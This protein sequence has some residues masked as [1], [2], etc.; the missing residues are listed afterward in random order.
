MYFPV[1]LL[2]EPES[3]LHADI[4]VQLAAL[5]NSDEWIESIQMVISS[6]SPIILAAS[7]RNSTRT[8]WAIIENFSLRLQK[9]V[10]DVTSED[11]SFAGRLMGDP[12]FDAYFTA[13]SN[14]ALI[15]LEDRRE[16][17]KTKFEQAGIPVGKALD[18]VSE[19]KKYL[20]VFEALSGLLNRKAF[21]ILDNDKGAK[22]CANYWKGKTPDR[23]KAGFHRYPVTDCIF[24]VLLPEGKNVEGLFEE[25]DD[26]LEAC[27]KDIYNDDYSFKAK[28]PTA[29]SRA[30]SSL[31]GKD[32]P[33]SIDEAKMLLVNEKDVK[34][35]FWEKVEEYN[36]CIQKDYQSALVDLLEVEA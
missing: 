35:T 36:Y 1:W 5:L 24:V 32:K 33:A 4:A 11:I 13:S 25:Y 30:T 15:F 34:D 14:Q 26:H 22:E 23:K 20:A 31:R 27:A 28:I 12:N 21:F 9:R 7:N 29:L 17:T 3:F 19:I 10:S 8:T 2:E 16:L 6:H 18:G